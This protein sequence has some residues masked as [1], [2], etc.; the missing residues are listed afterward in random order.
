MG[1]ENSIVFIQLE[2][3]QAE[4]LLRWHVTASEEEWGKFATSSF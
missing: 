1:G 3:S 2:R 4:L